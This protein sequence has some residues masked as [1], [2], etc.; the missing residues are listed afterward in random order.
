M[1]WWLIDRYYQ[2]ACFFVYVITGMSGTRTPTTRFRA[3][4][5]DRNDI[6]E[7][8]CYDAEA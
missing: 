8:S 4:T 2:G 3:G 6:L 1:G 7:G 5:T